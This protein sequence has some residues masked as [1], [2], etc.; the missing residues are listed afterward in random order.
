MVDWD[1]PQII[2]ATARSDADAFLARI[3]TL[4]SSL[5]LANARIEELTRANEA[6][7]LVYDRACKDLE[8]VILH[9]EAAEAALQR[10]R[11]ELA[12]I[13]AASDPYRILG[14]QRV[15]VSLPAALG[16]EERG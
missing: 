10:A 16:T 5:S 1:E 3:A 9:K 8:I 15:G 13:K 14:D 4:T 11:A 7:K 12:Q 6:L 2:G